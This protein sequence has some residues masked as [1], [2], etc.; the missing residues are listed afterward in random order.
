MNNKKQTESDLKIMVI[1]NNHP[2]L[3]KRSIATNEEVS[4]MKMFKTA[5]DILAKRIK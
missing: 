5:G 2:E 4:Q 1:D 3:S